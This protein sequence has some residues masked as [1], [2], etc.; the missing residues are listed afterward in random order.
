MNRV[1]VESVRRLTRRIGYEIVP[2]WRLSGLPLTSLLSDIFQA[3]RIDVVLD[4]GAN[5]GQYVSYL[6]EEL[7]YRGAVVSFEPIATNVELL[8]KRAGQFGSWRVC[9][10]ALGREEGRARFNLM[11]A[12]VFSSFL[13]PNHGVATEFSGMNTVERVEDVTVRRLDNVLNELA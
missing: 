10:V 13:S 7:G 1:L 4:V 9:D 11:Q 3:N 8:R 2:T 5:R 12:D 6:R